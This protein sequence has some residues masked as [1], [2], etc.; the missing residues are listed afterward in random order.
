MAT[1]RWLPSRPTHVNLRSSLRTLG[2]T[3]TLSSDSVRA[4]CSPCRTPLV[5]STDVCCSNAHAIV[6]LT[7]WDSFTR[8]DY[9][10]IFESMQRPA[11]V[12]DGRNLL[13][14]DLLR[15]IGFTV[16]GIGKPSSMP[17]SAQ[18]KQSA[19]LEET[20]QRARVKAGAARPGDVG[21]SGLG[22][23]MGASSSTS[24]GDTPKPPMVTQETFGGLA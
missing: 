11:F 19:A 7:E 4:S 10:R 18:E 9:R 2:L 22:R 24:G 15:S 12:F 8:L 3:H 6:V 16:F 21:L 5:L 1:K 14:H 13:D 23:S 20:A 17:S